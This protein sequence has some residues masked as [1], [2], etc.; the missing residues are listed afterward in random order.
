MLQ[1]N[2]C[3]NVDFNNPLN[4]YPRPQLKRESYINL[5]GKW[6]FK[7]TKEETLPSDF[8]QSIVVPFCV[9][10]QL[11]TI[12]NGLISTSK[13]KYPFSFSYTNTLFMYS[14]EC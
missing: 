9:E 8:Y 11:S 7:I 2:F 1:T 12:K 14:F 6:D 4:E 13:G 3:E 10:S 5:N